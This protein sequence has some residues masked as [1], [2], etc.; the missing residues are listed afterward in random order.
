MHL[1]GPRTQRVIERE[2]AEPNIWFTV[3]SLAMDRHRQ[4]LSHTLLNFNQIARLLKLRFGPTRLT[5]GL[6]TTRQ[7]PEAMNLA[8]RLADI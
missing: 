6:E 7:S 5:F 3:G 8:Y 4:R 1:R 2:L